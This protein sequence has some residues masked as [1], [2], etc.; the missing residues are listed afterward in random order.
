VAYRF[1][2]PLW[3]YPGETNTWHFVTVPEADSDDIEARTAHTRKGF[4]SVRVVA[5]IGKTTWKTSVFPD[6]KK[7]AYVLPVKKQVRVSEGL[8]A[9]TPV[10]LRIELDE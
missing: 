6:S 1:T 4:G 2:A 8:E 5:T 7:G 3:V 10:K 9:G